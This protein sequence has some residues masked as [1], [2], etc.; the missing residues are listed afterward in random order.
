M[1]LIFSSQIIHLIDET[2]KLHL[3]FLLTSVWRNKSVF[4]IVDINDIIQGISRDL[5]N[6]V[7]VRTRFQE[8]IMIISSLSTAD[9][10]AIFI[11]CLEFLFFDWSQAVSN[12]ICPAGTEKDSQ[13]PNICY[14]SSATNAS[15]GP[16]VSW[17][18]ANSICNGNFTGATVPIFKNFSE[19]NSYRNL[20]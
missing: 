4:H 20:V 19:Y 7:S 16:L 1:I 12:I 14:F 9:H 2:L 10:F 13:Y 18:Q 17:A 8:A 11:I 15:A 6:I 5:K 3:S